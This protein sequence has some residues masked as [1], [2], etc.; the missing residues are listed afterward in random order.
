MCADTR[1]RVDPSY[2]VNYAYAD[3]ARLGSRIALYGLQ[4]PRIDLVAQVCGALGPTDGLKILDVGTGDGRYARAIARSGANVTALDLS[5]G[6]VSEVEGVWA[7]LCADAQRLPFRDGSIDRLIAAHMLYH[8]ARPEHALAE[9][10][11]VLT[12]NGVTV[13]TSNTERHLSEM[14]RIWNESL[15]VQ[16]LDPTDSNFALRNL[17]LPVDRLLADLEVTFGRVESRLLTSSLRCD[18]VEPVV[19]YVASTTAAMTTSELG[20]DVVTPFGE[21]V[22]R[23]IER[24]GGFEVTTEVVLI[25]C[26][27]PI[28]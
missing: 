15:M 18:E 16:G 21:Q 5:L 9:F 6:M 1:R 24:D 25:S 19:R 3:R 4:E 10:A 27:E 26:T 20:H 7:R 2:L 17:E 11:R 13:V 22:R 8:L 12:A 28:R 23:F 14:A